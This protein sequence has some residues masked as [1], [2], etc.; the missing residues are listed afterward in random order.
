MAK[1]WTNVLQKKMYKC[2]TSLWRVFNI[3]SYQINTNWNNTNRPLHNPWMNKIKGLKIP[4]ADED[5]GQVKLSCAA[6]GS[7]K[8]YSYIGKQFQNIIISNI[9]SILLNN[10]ILTYS[11]KRKKHMSI[12]DLHRN[13]HRRFIYNSLQYGKET[14]NTFWSVN[15]QILWY[16][17]MIKAIQQ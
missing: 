9:H 17:Y 4:T 16:I 10:L 1:Y 6:G 13:V 3:T 11:L 2:A 8:C 14:A 12:N 7:A 5:V 15:G